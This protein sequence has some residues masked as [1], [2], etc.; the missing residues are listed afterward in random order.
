MRQALTLAIEQGQGRDAAVL[1]NNLALAIWQYEGPQAALDCLPGGDRL[2]PSGAASPSSRSAIAGMST[3]F[4][5]ELGQAEQALAEAAPLA[6]RLEAAGDIS[7]IEPRSVQLRLLAERGAHE[8]APAADELLTAARD[9]GQPQCYAQAFA[10]AARLLLAQGHR[11]AGTRAPATNSTRS[12]TSAPTPTTPR[13]CPRSCAPPSPSPDPSSPTGSSTASSRA[14]PSTS[15]PSTPPTPS[16]PKPPT[17]TPK[18]PALYAEAAERW[19][20]FG[21]VPERAYALLGQGRCL[22]ATRRRGRPAPLHEA[23][24]LFSLDG[25]HTRSRRSTQPPRA[26]RGCGGAVATNCAKSEPMHQTPSSERRPTWA[27]VA[28]MSRRGSL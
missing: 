19:H 24:E 3:T 17:T 18:P 23:R 21:N 8:H 5:A 4:L 2:L 22:T 12:R 1:H 28:P 13:P 15:T 25:L 26:G 20:Q 27:S 9:S 16:S 11:R 10:A 6:D 14:H 7:S